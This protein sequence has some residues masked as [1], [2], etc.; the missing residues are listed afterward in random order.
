MKFT[1][2]DPQPE[3]DKIIPTHRIKLYGYGWTRFRLISFEADTD[4]GFWYGRAR[5]QA[6]NGDVRWIDF[7]KYNYTNIESLTEN[8]KGAFP[9]HKDAPRV[10]G[11]YDK[12]VLGGTTFCPRLGEMTINAIAHTDETW[13]AVVMQPKEGD[14]WVCYMVNTKTGELSN[15]VFGDMTNVFVRFAERVNPAA[16]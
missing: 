12:A 3:D 11:G 5:V 10:G 9:F 15:G 13:A 2:V 7:G 6:M 1:T 8:D 4:Y 16:F 14:E